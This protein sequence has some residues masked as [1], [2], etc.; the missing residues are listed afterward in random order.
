M[1]IAGVS[2][3]VKV[4]HAIARNLGAGLHAPETIVP[5]R[6]LASHVRKVAMGTIVVRGASGRIVPRDALD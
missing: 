3:A 6:A 4:V 1:I 5:A 2:A